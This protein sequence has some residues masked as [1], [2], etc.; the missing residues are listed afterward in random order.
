MKNRFF[1][2]M[3]IVLSITGC[4][5]FQSLIQKPVVE[6]DSV[7]IKDISLFDCTAVFR[8][9]VTNPNSISLNLE[10]LSYQLRID[11]RDFIKGDFQAAIHLPANNAQA[12]DLPIHINYLEFFRSM[13]EVSQ[14]GT[15]NYDISGTIDLGLFDV[16]YSHQGTLALPR[17][18]KGLLKSS[19][20][21]KMP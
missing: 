9:R 1:L 21:W 14:K 2:V 19:S 18:P 20:I 13:A 10:N 4:V 7:S 16:P 3:T 6:L 15:H 5:L 12:V 17:L 11:G 8:F